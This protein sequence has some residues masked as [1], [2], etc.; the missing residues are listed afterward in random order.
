MQRREWLDIAKGIAIVLVVYGHAVRGLVM[1]DLIDPANGWGLVDYLIYSV[2]MPVF[3]VVSGY[4]FDRSIDKGER[5]FA[6]SRLKT[7]VWP[8]FL[9]TG[10]H[11][12][13]QLVGSRMGLA[14]VPVE[15]GRILTI[16][17]DPVS[18]FWF[19][20]ALAVSMLVSAIARPMSPVVLAGVGAAALLALQA[21]G[22][23]Q[24]INDVF[25]GL[26]YFSLG[27]S[28]RG[29]DLSFLDRPAFWAATGVAFAS[30]ALAG[31]Q[32]DVPVRLNFLAGLSGLAFFFAMCRAVARYATAARVLAV[33]GVY[34]MGIF[35]MHVTVLGV[36]RAL[37]LR[38]FDGAIAPT[39]IL[40]TLLAVALPLAA[41][42]LANALGI[43]GFFGLKVDKAKAPSESSQ[44]DPEFEPQ[45]SKQ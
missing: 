19:L 34:S 7:I 35:V 26:L 13:A 23:P 11:V 24:V 33:L 14:N 25:Y 3:F 42:W 32:M 21:F 9:W 4:L 36:G 45:M 43:A 39:L 18:P 20:Y 15:P 37:G 16:L 22:G 10:L 31:Y 44:A 6:A 40:Q 2:H 8:Y 38:L 12:L 1:A 17:W 27:R 28:L 29:A 41:Q 5:Q 30:T